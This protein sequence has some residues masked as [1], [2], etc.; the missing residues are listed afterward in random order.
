MALGLHAFGL[1]LMTNL[2]PLA[3]EP[4]PH[5][6]SRLQLE[7]FINEQPTKLIGD[8]YR[9]AD[10]TFMARRE[11]MA[12]LGIVV[13]GKGDA[14]DFVPFNGLAELSMRFVENEQK[15]YLTLPE[16]LRLA[17]DYDLRG[18]LMPP[19]EHAPEVSQ[20]FGAVVN[21]NAYGTAA[22]GFSS[23]AKPYTLG[24]LTLEGRAF[25]PY[26]VFQNSAIL[27]TSLARREGMRLESAYVYAHRNSA[28]TTTLGD[29]IS[30][31]LNW[32]RPVRFG[33]VQ[34]SRA[35]G[36]RPDLVTAP[37]PS[38]GGSAA[39]PS[40][41]D[42]FVDNM[43]IA[44]QEIGAGPYRITNL[45]VS[46][47]SGTARVVVRDITGKETTT[48]LPFFA[49]SKLL[50]P[51]TVD[52]S[53]DAGYARRN[54]ALSSFDYD[55]HPMGQGSVRYG[56]RDTIT[57]EA[58]GEGMAGLALIGGGA[59]VNAGEL[60]VI[61]LAGAGS[62]NRVNSSSVAWGGLG[63][64]SWQINVSGVFFGISTQRTLGAYTDIA[65]ATATTNMPRVSTAFLDSGFF[66]FNRSTRVPRSLDRLS[67]GR[68][69][70]S[71]N[72]SAS[73]NLVSLDRGPGDISRQASLTWS[74]TFA[75]K[76]DTFVTVFSDFGTRR[77]VGAMAGLSFALG[78]DI[79]ISSSANMSGTERR[80]GVSA[81]RPPG[82]NDYD[83]GW[84]LQADE[85]RTGALRGAEFQGRTPYARLGAGLRQDGP[86]LGGYGEIEG[87]VIATRSGVFAARRVS[88]AFAVVD[89]GAPNV[90]VLVENRPAGRTGPSGKMVVN[91]VRSLQRTK[92]AVAPESLPGMSHATVTEAEIMP[93]FRGAS[94]VNVHV[95]A[96]RNTARVHLRDASGKHFAAGTRVLHQESGESSTIG[97]GGMTYLTSV[98]PVSTLTLHHDTKSC[99][100]SFRASDRRGERA[101]VGP[102][103]CALQ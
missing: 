103:T 75:R 93:N 25:S 26:G 39:V 19:S 72:A 70:P 47:E 13:P 97:Y 67:V 98:S 17:R 96:A 50:A 63:Y 86:T 56:L 102:L 12:S 8:I 60:G 43:R 55:R 40:T 28:T 24:S 90:E 59:T 101:E 18:T 36:L 77:Q 5:N 4:P 89:V 34:I 57:L 44:S 49:S 37:L 35:F 92:I 38:V 10:G 31:G 78:D 1:L 46:G 66:A 42:I 94:T 33:G 88:D 30:G 80:S 6:L 74:Q 23:A 9:A 99:S 54:Y 51:G 81:S 62:W 95:I 91:D 20:E 71:I 87:S 73:A 58:H 14:R 11:E 27:G 48:T 84:R 29:A 41:V 15:L 64:L 61:S 79:F 45:P 82:Q 7:V 22:R 16:S 83:Y 53:L 76:Y 32:S 2:M 85:G 65:A 69:F 21:Y 100:V 68:S 52:F 3:K